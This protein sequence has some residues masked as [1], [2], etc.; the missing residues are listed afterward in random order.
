MRGV[1]A[2]ERRRSRAEWRRTWRSIPYAQ[3]R[4][5][6]EALRR[7]GPV[8]DPALADLAAEAAERRIRGDEGFGYPHVQGLIGAAQAVAGA[9]LAASSAFDGDALGTGFGG[10]MV[11]LAGGQ[12]VLWRLE[13]RRL[14]R[15][16]AANRAL[17][18]QPRYPADTT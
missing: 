12:L 3:Q 16:A 14:E 2:D 1:L 7:G 5:V 10:A 11:A 9:G 6:R 8:E 17:A 13:R 4:G 18:G 15:A